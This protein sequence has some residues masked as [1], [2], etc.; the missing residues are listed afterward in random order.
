MGMAF[1]RYL[2]VTLKSSS[3]FPVKLYYGQLGNLGVVVAQDMFI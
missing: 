1:R 2:F 3:I